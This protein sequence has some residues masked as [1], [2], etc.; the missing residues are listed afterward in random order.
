MSRKLYIIGDIDNLSYRQFTEELAALE[1]SIAPVSVEIHSEGGD[2]EVALAFYARIKASPCDVY[3]HTNGVVASSAVLVYAA[4]TKR[5]MASTG[6][7][8][9]HECQG[10]IDG[11]TSDKAHTLKHLQALEDQWNELMEDQT[12]TEAK[13]WAAL[14][15]VTT[16]LTANQAKALGLVHKVV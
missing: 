11:S 6:W 7:V 14:N 10:K 2:A 8:M 9:V 3:M 13:E 12:G 16:H 5:T 1:S 4:G 15:K